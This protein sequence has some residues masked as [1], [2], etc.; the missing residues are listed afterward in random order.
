MN[1]A[2]AFKKETQKTFTENGQVATIQLGIV[3][4]IYLV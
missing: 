2:Q 3:V 1:F 4:L